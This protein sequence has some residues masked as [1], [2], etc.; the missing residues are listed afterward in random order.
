MY[1]LNIKTLA[2]FKDKL[3]MICNIYTYKLYCEHNI[4]NK[5]KIS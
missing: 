3:V 5:S 2:T 1:L 4:Y